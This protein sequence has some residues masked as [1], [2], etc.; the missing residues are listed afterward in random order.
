MYVFVYVY[1]NVY[2]QLCDDFRELRFT[3]I[4]T[5]VDLDCA[6]CLLH[7]NQSPLKSPFDSQ[8]KAAMGTNMTISS[9]NA[10]PLVQQIRNLKGRV[11][12]PEAKTSDLFEHHDANETVAPTIVSCACVL[13][14]K[15]WEFSPGP[16]LGTYE[17]QTPRMSRLPC[18]H[19]LHSVHII[20]L[21]RAL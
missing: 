2:L 3:L 12:Q 8:R 20:L 6:A 14:Q 21:A 9:I 13:E 5:I 16:L 17:S 4:R 18:T 11:W 7:P 1:V 10:I 15:C 19:D